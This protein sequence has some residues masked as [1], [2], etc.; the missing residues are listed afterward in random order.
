MSQSHPTHNPSRV[1]LDSSANLA[2]LDSTDAN[3]QAAR[4]IQQKLIQFRPQIFTTNFITDESYT[5]ILA[6]LGRDA[7]I[8]YLDRLYASSFTVARVSPT[9]E[10][11]AEELL[12]QYNDKQF[13]YTDATSFVVMDRLHLT[14][15]F[16]F[17]RDFEQYGKIVLTP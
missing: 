13:S 15:A 7:A 17:D 2:L 14:Y 16:T 3:H 12:R 5:L 10:R 1:F 9:D 4:S 11:R 8:A 6:N